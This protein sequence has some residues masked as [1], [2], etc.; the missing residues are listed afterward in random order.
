MA[1]CPHSKFDR[2]PR[3]SADRMRNILFDSGDIFLSFYGIKPDISKKNTLFKHIIFSKLCL[4]LK[5]KTYW[6]HCVNSE[7]SEINLLI[8]CS[9][10]A[11]L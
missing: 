5:V 11:Q 3:V 10:E 8:I 9:N 4:C 6:A 2:E 7:L 1:I